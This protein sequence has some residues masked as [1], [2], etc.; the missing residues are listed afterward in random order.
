M[1][2]SKFKVGDTVFPIHHDKID[3]YAWPTLSPYMESYSGKSMTI[4]SV[5]V[6]KAPMEGEI[7]LYLLSNSYLYRE[8]WLEKDLEHQIQW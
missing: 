6:S 1:V 2:E 3:I 8:E 7:I 4:K 5:Y